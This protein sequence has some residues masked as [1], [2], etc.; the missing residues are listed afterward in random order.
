ME[1]SLSNRESMKFP[2][3]IG[4]ELLKQNFIVDVTKENHS[5]K[6]KVAFQL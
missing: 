1:T 5:F 3:L 4:R 6:A 2:L